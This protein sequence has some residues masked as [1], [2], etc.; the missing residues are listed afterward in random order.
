MTKS[1]DEL[2]QHAST[3][4]ITVVGTAVLYPITA[5]YAQGVYDALLW[6]AGDDPSESLADILELNS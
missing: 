6:L 2:R 1:P 3:A 4:E 5:A